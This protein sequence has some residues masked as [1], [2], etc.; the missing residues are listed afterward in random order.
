LPE[1]HFAKAE[2]FYRIGGRLE[3]AEREIAL[4]LPGMPN[5]APLHTLAGKVWRRQARW[6]EAEQ[7]LI[8]AVE[9][10]PKNANAI[11]FLAD[12]QILVR[13]YTDAIGTYER[14]RAAGFDPVLCAVRVGVID[15]SATGRSERLRAAL[16]RGPAD[17]DVSG[18]ETPWRIMFALMDRDYERAAAALAS[19][20]RST[21]QDVDQSFHY[22]RSW[23]E[24]VIARAA[25]RSDEA[26]AA[27]RRAL[28]DLGADEKNLRI[29]FRGLTV[30]AQARAAVGEK[31]L[32]I[33]S[34]ERAAETVGVGSNAYDQPLIQQGLAQVYTWTG[35][36]ER[37]LE[38][39]ERLVKKPGYLSYGHL[40]H[41]P[42][43][44]PLRGSPRFQA[45]VASIAPR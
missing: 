5:S 3:Q 44:E 2:N 6:H 15:F 29:S 36:H 33:E 18:G 31:E 8:K 26:R 43:W 38:I 32:A 12:T 13:R 4:A 28:A 30:I 22:P 45:I 17:L 27:F 16:A 1:A 7:V 35:E 20:P 42:A 21:F 40:L 39:V 10:D 34:A 24:G 23:Y 14:A 37:A 19:S 25:G 41:D 11:T 9:L